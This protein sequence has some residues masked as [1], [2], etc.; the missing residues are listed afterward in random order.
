[1]RVTASG[2]E[3]TLQADFVALFF[4][5]LRARGIA[6][7]LDTCGQC[8]REALK[9][10]LPYSNMVLYDLKEIDPARHRR[11]TGVDNQVILDNLL[12]VRDA[13]LA[14]GDPRELWIRTPIIPGA[15]AVEENIRGIGRFI[16]D[17]MA[18]TVARRDLCAFNNLCRDKYARL[19]LDWEFKGAELIDEPTLSAL[20]AAAETS[21]VDPQIVRA[22]GVVKR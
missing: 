20:K 6:T 19:G 9:K 12:F 7:A 8:S 15:T 14:A 11:F 2:G 5:A 18:G 22:S 16:A 3:A 4:A 10:I 13:V 17:N 1:M 21:G